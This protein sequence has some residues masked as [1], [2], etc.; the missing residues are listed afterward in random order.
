M[1]KLFFALALI[2]ALMPGLALAGGS[3]PTNCTDGRFCDAQLGLSLR[4]PSGWYVVG[5]KQL[6][7]SNQ[8]AFAAPGSSGLNYNLRL[9]IRA[10][11]MTSFE[12]S[13]QSVQRLV[14]K[15][16]RAER[17]TGVQQT[18]VHYAGSFG[19]L[20]RGLPSGPTPGLDILL[21][22]HH[23]VY[24][25][26]A[27]GTSLAPDQIAALTSLRFIPIQGPFLGARGV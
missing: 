26:I 7:G 14:A 17:V 2:S 23:D 19:V 3:A 15:L 24:Q 18:P 22:R 6:A 13:R 20:I 1:K 4:L 21:G 25:I 5:A 12:S 8:V 27:P 10:Y 9:I 16:I 11:A